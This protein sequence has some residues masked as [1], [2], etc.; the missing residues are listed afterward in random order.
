MTKYSF[1][2]LDKEL[3]PFLE[4]LQEWEVMDITRSYKSVDETSRNYIERAHRY[5]AALRNLKNFSVKEETNAATHSIQWDS[6]LE[7]VE[8]K[9]ELSHSLTTQH[10]ELQKERTSAQVWGDFN[11]EDLNR[12]AALNLVP[13][14]YVIPEKK[15]NPEWEK[16]FSLQQLNHLNGKIYFVILVSKFDEEFSFPLIETKFPERSLHEIDEAITQ[17]ENATKENNSEL[18]LLQSQIDK[19]KEQKQD[20]D[21]ILDLY[22]ANLASEKAAEGQIAVI[23]GFS[24]TEKDK[25]LAEKLEEC[26]VYYI[27]EPA[28]Q[29]DNPPIK[30]KNNFFASLFEPIGNLYMLPKYGELDL[31]PFFAPF[32]MLFFGLCLGDMG[33]GLLLFIGGLIGTFKLPKFKN[34]AKLVMLLGLGSIIMPA[35]TGTF[36][37]VSLYDHV[38][39]P[40][41]LYDTWYNPATINIKMF[42][43]ALIFGVFQICVGRLISAIYAFKKKGWQYGLANIGWAVFTVWAAI[44]FAEWQGGFTFL[45]PLASYIMLGIAGVCILFFSKITN[46]IFFRIAG[47][48]K[49]V[50]DVTGLLGDILSYVRLFGLGAAGGILGLVMNQIALSLG[51]IPYVG[52]LLFLIMIVIGHSLVIFLSCLGA[53][54]HP[55]R[56]TFVEFYKNADFQGGGRKFN[57][58]KKQQE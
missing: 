24:P 18:L 27:A 40:Q 45:S 31:T 41:W 47:G 1:I 42:W 58:L 53:F 11:S 19:L 4:K 25:E 57:P 6:L 15:F 7:T 35:L 32:Y 36:F 28:T 10:L 2:L 21:A 22:L 51:T 44:F 56:L 5:A 54:V 29:E 14:F 50:Y 52:W 38:A 17:N 48:V 8:E 33:Y 16:A 34:Y 9:L 46:N 30:L 20:H 12:L 26:A 55:I 43:F 23:Q 37:G 39:M 49:A 3:N 13:H